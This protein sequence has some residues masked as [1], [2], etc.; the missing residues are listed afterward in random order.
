MYPDFFAT[1]NNNKLREVNEILGQNLQQ[2]SLELLEPQGVDAEEVVYE[3]AK[4]AF[5]KAGKPVL[6]EDTS[7]EFVAWNGLPGALIRWFLDSVGIKGILKMLIGEPDRRAVA[8][9]A[10][11]FFDGER[12]H[13]FVGSIAGTISDTVRGTTHFGWDPIFIPK[14]Q[15]R[16]FA[17]MTPAEKNTI[18]MRK[19]ALD[20]MRQALH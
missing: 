17:E 9:T 8:K 3:K 7:L 1:K 15:S 11:G 2:I 12:V 13:V 4:D 16:S 19:L 6:V 5:H 10:V 20:K 18:S 14:G